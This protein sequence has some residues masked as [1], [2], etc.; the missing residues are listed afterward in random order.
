[1]KKD[2][3]IPNTK[4]D[5]QVTMEDNK[6]VPIV[7]ELAQPIQGEADWRK[8]RCLQ[9]SNGITACCVNDA[10]SKTTAVATTVNVGAAHDPRT[11]SGLAR[12]LIAT[13]I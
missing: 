2:Y 9:L 3:G 7:R 12:T 6:D 4:E 1:L 8:Y 11:I 10:T 13:L 5:T